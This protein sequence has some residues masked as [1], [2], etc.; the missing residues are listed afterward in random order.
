MESNTSNKQAAPDWELFKENAQPLK[1]GR[2]AAHLGSALSARAAI[3]PL[4]VA[5]TTAAA[6]TA[7][8][9]EFEALVAPSALAQSDDP[10]APWLRYIKWVGIKRIILDFFK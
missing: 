4:A 9:A 7:R 3:A 5:A 2:N 1:R 6:T 10:I 8:M